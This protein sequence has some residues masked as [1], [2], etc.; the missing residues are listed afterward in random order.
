MSRSIPALPDW[1]LAPYEH[2]DDDYAKSVQ[3]E[4]DAPRVEPLGAKRIRRLQKCFKCGYPH[5]EGEKCVWL[6]HNFMYSQEKHKV[7]VGKV[8]AA[9]ILS[10]LEREYLSRGRRPPVDNSSA[11]L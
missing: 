3:A 2:V 10:H 1:M 11:H 4:M 7:L 5:A 6:N 8:L 9:P